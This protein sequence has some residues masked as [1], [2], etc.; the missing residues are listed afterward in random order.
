LQ[1]SLLGTGI[2]TTT[3]VTGG[4]VLEDVPADDVHFAVVDDPADHWGAIL[5]LAVSFENLTIDDPVVLFS[6]A[7][8]AL[9]EE[10]LAAE[11]SSTGAMILAAADKVGPTVDID[12]P[13][14]PSSYFSFGAGELQLGVS[15]LQSSCYPSVIYFGLPE[16]DPGTHQVS[17][18]DVAECPAPGGADTPPLLPHHVSYAV[19]DC[20]P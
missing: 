12:P 15:T 6:D 18:T 13:V 20:T 4:F 8:V 1:V 16:G 3:D 2:E 14:P 11:I 17:V 5:P 19:F 10:E 7:L 9:A